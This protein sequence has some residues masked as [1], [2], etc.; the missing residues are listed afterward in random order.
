MYKIIGIDNFDRESID[1]ILVKDKL[2]KEDADKFCEELNAS[3]HDNH[4]YFYQV[5]EQEKKLHR[6]SDLY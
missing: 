3:T 6:V 1:D 4:P 5:V 2:T